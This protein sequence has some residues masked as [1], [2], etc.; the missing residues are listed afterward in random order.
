MNHYNSLARFFHWAM[1]LLV[2]AAVAL[3]LY[4]D[5]MPFSAEKFT[6]IQRHKSL[7]LT[8][9]ALVFAR[10]AWRFT[11]PAPLLPAGMPRWQKL[12]AHATHAMLYVLMFAVPLSGYLMSDAAGYH[13]TWF[14]VP[15]PVLMQPDA[16]IAKALNEVHE[17]A[18]W[19]LV[20]LVVLHVGAALYHHFY[21]RDD[22]LRRMLP[23]TISR[24]RA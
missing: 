17:V 13:P 12:L 20:A 11:T 23:E 4:M 6:L 9:L 10:A 21:V 16:A 5:D 14:G 15:V 19:T 7:G 24:R 22:T 2:A 18:A 8:V 1:A 3:A